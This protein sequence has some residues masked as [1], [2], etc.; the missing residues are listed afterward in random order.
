M[1]ITIQMGFHVQDKTD[2]NTFCKDISNAVVDVAD[3]DYLRGT[4]PK[5][6]KKQREAMR[7]GQIKAKFDLIENPIVSR[8]AKQRAM[9][10]LVG[11]SF[12]RNSLMKQP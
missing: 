2:F 7:N 12:E 9:A 8:F 3:I 10:D 6:K 1:Y 4:T 11:D 5:G